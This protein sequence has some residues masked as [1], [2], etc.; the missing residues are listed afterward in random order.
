MT[1]LEIGLIVFSVA[2]IS[3]VWLDSNKAKKRE[4][5]LVNK[6]ADS[7]KETNRWIKNYVEQVKA[8]ADL[9][10]ELEK[11]KAELEQYKNEHNNS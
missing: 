8:Y 1:G 5:E 3:A 11:T 6:W 7:Q 9:N 2:Y 10:K 4:V